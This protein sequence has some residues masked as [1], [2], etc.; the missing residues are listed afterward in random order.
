MRSFLANLSGWFGVSEPET[1]RAGSLL[2]SSR[3]LAPSSVLGSAYVPRIK[4][5]SMLYRLE[6]AEP[7]SAASALSLVVRSKGDFFF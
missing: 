1:H 7:A 4:A 3:T 6:D 5:E 2:S